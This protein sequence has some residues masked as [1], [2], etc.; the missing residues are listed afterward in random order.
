MSLLNDFVVVNYDVDDVF[1]IEF[2]NQIEVYGYMR[3]L[4]FVGYLL[5]FMVNVLWMLYW[6]SM[7]E[8][9]LVVLQV[10]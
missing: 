8:F 3:G 6:D 5:L 1:C 10:Y 4:Q 7:D 2:F 9:M